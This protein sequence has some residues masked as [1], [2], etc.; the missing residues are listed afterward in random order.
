MNT[1]FTFSAQ[2]KAISRNMDN[3]Y[4]FNMY[5]QNITCDYCG[6]VHAYSKCYVDNW[7]YTSFEQTNFVGDFYKPLNNSYFNTYY[8]ET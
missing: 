8:L 4:A 2:F 6:R 7:F 1:F 5:V 3:F